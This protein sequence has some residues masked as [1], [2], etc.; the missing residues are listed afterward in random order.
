MSE[1][2]DVITVRRCRRRGY[3][4]LDQHGKYVGCALTLADANRFAE[5]IGVPVG[6]ELIAVEEAVGKVRYCWLDKLRV[7]L[8]G[9]RLRHEA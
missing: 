6:L 5:T 9:R 7:C 8:L 3:E 4:L 1:R 2:G